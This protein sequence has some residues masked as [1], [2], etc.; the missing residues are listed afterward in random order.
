MAPKALKLEPI[1]GSE[2]SARIIHSTL[3]KIAKEARSYTMVEAWNHTKPIYLTQHMVTVTCVRVSTTETNPLVK[4]IIGLNAL[5]PSGH[6]PETFLEMDGS[7]DFVYLSYLFQKYS[8]MLFHLSRFHR[9]QRTEELWLEAADCC[10]VSWVWIA[11]RCDV[12]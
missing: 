11:E 8:R 6:E 1:G 12:S 9:S 2:T 10:G 4:D 3:P 7:V 5:I